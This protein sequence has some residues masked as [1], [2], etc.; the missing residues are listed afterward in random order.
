VVADK[1]W[2]RREFR[3]VAEPAEPRARGL[4]RKTSGLR[5][6]VLDHADVVRVGVFK[7]GQGAPIGGR[8]GPWVAASEELAQ[9]RSVPVRTCKRRVFVAAERV[10]AYQP[11]PFAAHRI[12]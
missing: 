4:E 9:N 10:A 6:E 2:N 7:E 1:F 8:D 11:L 12:D 5:P 3:R